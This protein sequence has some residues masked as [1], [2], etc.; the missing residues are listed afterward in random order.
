M[1]QGI[2]NLKK[3]DPVQEALSATDSYETGAIAD[4]GADDEDEEAAFHRLVGD[5]FGG[6]STDSDDF[7]GMV[8]AAIKAFK[9]SPVPPIRPVSEEA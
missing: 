3:P 8:E 9:G 7:R 5:R 6:V 2:D 4:S 1:R